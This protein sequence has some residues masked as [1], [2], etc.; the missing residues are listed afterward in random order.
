MQS[1]KIFTTKNLFYILIFTLSTPCFSQTEKDIVKKTNDYVS[2]G[3][4]ETAYNYLDSL[5][6]KNRN[7]DIVLLKEGIALNFYIETYNH[8]RFAF[9][10]LD[11]NQKINDFRGKTTGLKMHIFKINKVLDS[12][13]K[14]DPHNYKLYKGLGDYYYEVEQ[15]Y[16]NDWLVKEKDLLGLIE[17]NYTGALNDKTGD[18]ETNYR[19]GV[20]Y[21]TDGNYQAGI[22]FF[23]KAVQLNDSSADAHYNLAYAFLNVNDTLNALRHSLAATK[24]YQD[25][26]SK[27]DAARMA[28]VVLGEM[29]KQKKAIEFMELSNKIAPN[30]YNTLK[31]LIDMYLKVDNRK[32]EREVTEQFYHLGVEK[33]T[34][35]NDLIDIYAGNNKQKQLIAFFQSQLK[36]AN[37]DMI[38]LGSLYFSIGKLYVGIDKNLALENLTKASEVFATVY[39]PEN[40]VF[41]LIYDMMKSLK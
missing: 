25:S 10:D 37:G 41:K 34:I 8:Q 20:T 40:P 38:Q 15:K 36:P 18:F 11:K 2:N 16:G 35:Y 12:L 7:A 1:Q 4:Y 21:E 30:N 33:P 9:K 23:L 22:P 13:I 5:D 14:V 31:I 32:K 39:K 24:L 28:G 19:L 6:P 17:Y 3:K 27:G 26:S 29:G